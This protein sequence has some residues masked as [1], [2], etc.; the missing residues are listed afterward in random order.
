MMTWTD[1]RRAISVPAS[2]Q[3]AFVEAR[4]ENSGFALDDVDPTL[5]E[6]VL[7]TIP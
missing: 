4:V 6:R 2:W 7:E 3:S 1:E 5:L